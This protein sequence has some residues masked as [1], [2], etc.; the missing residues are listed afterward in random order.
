M[1]PE[2]GRI[3]PRSARTS[4]VHGPPS[5]SSPSLSLHPIAEPGS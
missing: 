1:L 5:R 4:R 2:G 3:R